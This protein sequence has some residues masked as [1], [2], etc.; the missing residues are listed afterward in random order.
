MYHYG[1]TSH[2]TVQNSV[3]WGD[4]AH[5]ILIGLG[6]VPDAH[7]SDL[8]FQNI[9]VL[10]EQGVYILDKFTGVLKLWANGGERLLLFLRKSVRLTI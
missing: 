4:D 1:T 5:T 2:N 6:S 3:L 9:D 10:N 7:I 8:T